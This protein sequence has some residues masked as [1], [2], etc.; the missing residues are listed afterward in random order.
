M[1]TDYALVRI[2]KAGF[3]A[4]PTGDAIRIKDALEWDAPLLAML[5]C[6]KTSIVLSDVVHGDSVEVPS[7][8]WHDVLL[9][10]VRRFP[11]KAHRAK[12]YMS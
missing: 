8:G 12:E 5:T 7:R 3:I 2:R 10:L 9:E 4:E 1:L 6:P 11:R